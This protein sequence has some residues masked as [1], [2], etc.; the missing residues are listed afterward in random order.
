MWFNIDRKKNNYVNIYS[1]SQHMQKIPDR[2]QLAFWLK[3]LEMINIGY[4][5]NEEKYINHIMV[6][7]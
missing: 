1:T 7:C 4:F 3:K 5:H 6:Q 2:G